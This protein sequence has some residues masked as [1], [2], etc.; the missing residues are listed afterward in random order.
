[1]KTNMYLHNLYHNGVDLYKAL[2]DE[3]NLTLIN[4]P[5]VKSGLT[6]LQKACF[7][8]QTQLVATS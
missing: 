2:N 7:Y 6:I 5:D 4:Q 1:M 3:G 8:G